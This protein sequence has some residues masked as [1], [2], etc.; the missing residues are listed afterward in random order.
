MSAAQRGEVYDLGFQ[1][2]GGPREGRRRARLAVYK[3]G[4][5]A[6][7]GIGRG[8]RA[9]ILPWIFIGAAS[10]TAL[11]MA[12]VAGAVDRLAP[13][14]EFDLPSHSD[15]YDFASIILLIFA[16]TVGPELLCPDRRSGVINL[17]LVRPLTGTD[18]AAARWLALFTIMLL[19]AWL[20][21]FILLAG[22]TLSANDPV[23]YLGDN[24]LDVPR[25]LGAGFAIALFTSTLALSVASF[26]TRRAFAAAFIVGL[27]VISL[28]FAEGLSRDVEENVG[29]W[30][31]LLNIGAVPIHLNDI[32][33][34]EFRGA[35]DDS[36]AKALP[37]A[38]LV[39]WYVLLTAGPGLILWLKYRR[40]SP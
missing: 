31:A 7:L 11:I 35:A 15:Y 37:N 8:G 9:K 30:L 12:L 19:V 28:P 6:A 2:Y 13:G 5:R 34:D 14:A 10:L 38:I 29:K 1:R 22:L 23:G 24:W 17:Y 27:F 39:L 18:Y 26:T 32:I 25:F 3:D 40:F 33:F 36:P 21:Q 4:I 20:P 16:A